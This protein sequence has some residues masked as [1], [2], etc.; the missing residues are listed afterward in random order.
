MGELRVDRRITLKW[1]LKITQNSSGSVYDPVGRVL[2]NM[3]IKF[4]V[5]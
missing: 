1:F 5:R 3:E 4:R 2:E